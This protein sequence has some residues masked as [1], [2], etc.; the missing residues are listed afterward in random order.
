MPLAAVKLL[1]QSVLAVRS[2]ESSSD[3]VNHSYRWMPASTVV[4]PE[5]GSAQLIYNG[6]GTG[7]VQCPFA[8]E[9]HG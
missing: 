5:V 6:G 7:L 2:S 1:M 4:S 9:L 8:E 3:A